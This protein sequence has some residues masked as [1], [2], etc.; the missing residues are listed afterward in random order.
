M[1]GPGLWQSKLATLAV[2]V[3]IFFIGIRLYVTATRAKDWV[4]TYATKMAV[5]KNPSPLNP[6]IRSMA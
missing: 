5:C 2:E 4:G 1:V 6:A 3:P